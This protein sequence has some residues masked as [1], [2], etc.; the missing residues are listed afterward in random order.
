MFVCVRCVGRVPDHAVE[1]RGVVFSV[2]NLVPGHPHRRSAQGGCAQNHRGY[3]LK[4]HSYM[5][6]LGGVVVRALDL[7]LEIAG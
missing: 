6:W 1:S 4:S 7:R 3:A 5:V 2:E